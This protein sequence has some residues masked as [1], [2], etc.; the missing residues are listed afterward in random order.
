MIVAPKDCTLSVD[1]LLSKGN[2]VGV[3]RGTTEANWMKENLIQKGK[4]FKL[5]EYDSA[6]LAIEDVLNGRIVA[7]AMDDAP[8]KDAMRKKPVKIVGT[9]GM[10]SE[11]FGYAVRKEDTELL[12]MMNEGLKKLMASTYWEELKTTY[13]P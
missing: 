11:D 6:P 7:A 13:K 4:D 8:A 10:P 9:F 12:N 5:V 3:Q 2:K 1:E